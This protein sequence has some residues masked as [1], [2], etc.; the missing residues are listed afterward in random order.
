MPK[1]PGDWTQVKPIENNRDW[2]LSPLYKFW[3]RETL[4]SLVDA[5]RII[6]VDGDK[7]PPLP[8][9]HEE[10]EFW[11]REQ[12]NLT[13]ELQLIFTEIECLYHAEILKKQSTD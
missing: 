4:V 13:P 9:G 7:I 8:E 10:H 1:K 12:L 2:V 3:N 5:K 11:Y 6:L